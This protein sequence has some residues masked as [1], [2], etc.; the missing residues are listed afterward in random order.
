MSAIL[1]KDKIE[2]CKEVFYHFSNGEPV[3]VPK[4]LKDALNALG[5][6]PTQEELD[7]IWKE[8]DVDGNGTIDIN[9][10]LD[11]FAQKMK[12]PDIEE[13]LYEAFKN[14][15]IFN[16][17]YISISELKRV[18]TSYGTKMTNSEFDNFV[19]IYLRAV[20]IE[21][22]KAR[23]ERKINGN[24]QAEEEGVNSEYDNENYVDIK[25]FVKILLD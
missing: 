13:D 18:M 25:K 11:I 21:K 23:L 5:A 15:D 24:T 17:G 8:I 22:E 3:L 12:D 7:K 1:P 14:F 16:S 4:Q 6:D 10:F 2:E 20:S 9:E 19:Q